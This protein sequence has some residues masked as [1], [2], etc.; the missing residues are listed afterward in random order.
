MEIN[1]N[2]IIGHSAQK[3]QLRTMLQEG[4]LP[5]ALL[6]SGPDGIGKKML[7]KLLAA[8]ILCGGQDAPCGHCESCQAM[9]LDSHPDY[10]EVLPESRGK[11]ARIIRIEQI[12]EMQTIASR[13]PI[14][15]SGRVVLIDEADR[16]NEAA[17]NSLL[18]TLEEPEGQVTFILITSARSSLLDTIISRC[19]P[20]AFGMLPRPEMK[21]ALME[22]QV[23]ADDAAE[24]AALADGSLGRAIT[25]YDNGGLTLRND[26]LAFLE[27][28]KRM[29]MEDVWT[30]ARTK[31]DMEREKLIEWFLYL[32]MLLRDMLV[33]YEDG[34]SP[35]L[36]HQDCRQ[37]LAELLP[38]YPESQI[39]VM[40][41]LVRE[42]QRRLQ[43][44]VNLR[45]QMEG[46]F[47]RI[48]DCRK[49]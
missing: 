39:F 12:R 40:L 14:L 33:L 10:Y 32:N 5:H 22:R 2:K 1:W 15:S 4:R 27:Q 38:E 35:L 13:Y 48:R 8:A 6:F 45:L 26:A 47:I 43:A 20:V 44:N 34:A 7:G 41:S 30:Q 31:G 28:L 25:L 11:S 46:F 36:Y 16:M 18:K 29:T 21:A 9:R 42:T 49:A 19:M 23:P 24:L 37:R 17:A 3:E